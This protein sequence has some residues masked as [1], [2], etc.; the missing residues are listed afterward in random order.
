LYLIIAAPKIQGT[1][2]KKRKKDFKS[3]RSRKSTLR[4]Y[5]PEIAWM[6]QHDTSIITLSKEN[7]N[8]ENINTH[9][10][11]DGKYSTVGVPTLDNQELLL[12]E[13]ISLS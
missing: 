3:Q 2:Q 11:E 8:N 4:M 5:P 12:R 6:L 13:K 10:H 7:P 9:S 1:L